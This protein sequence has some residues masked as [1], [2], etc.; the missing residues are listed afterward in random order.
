LCRNTQ[1]LLGI[2]VRL[3]L[4]AGLA[5]ISLLAGCQSGYKIT[6]DYG[7]PPPPSHPTVELT[8]FTYTPASPIHIGDTLTLT[9]VTTLPLA[10]GS[11]RASLPTTINRNVALNDDGWPPD[12]TAGDGIWTGEQMWMED[13]GTPS[14]GV[15]H[16]VLSTPGYFD[17][18]KFGPR[19]TVLPAEEE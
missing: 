7:V 9:A 5:L 11:M 18:A 16:L 4:S 13:M 1:R 14:D 19:L 8:D 12:Q 10:D 2:L 15:I 6:N 3:A 17:Q